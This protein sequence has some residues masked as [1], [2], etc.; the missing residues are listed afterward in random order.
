MPKK[1]PPS[2]HIAGTCG[3]N[4]DI[5]TVIRVGLRGNHLVLSGAH[6]DTGAVLAGDI[7]M[8]PEKVTFITMAFGGVTVSPVRQLR[9]VH[10]M[11]AV[12]GTL[13]VTIYPPLKEGIDIGDIH[14]NL[15]EGDTVTILPSHARAL[16]S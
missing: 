11:D 4:G 7:M 9:V 3:E 15:E 14:Q 5:L 16:I 10:D 1:Y 2:L 6:C 8:L 13:V 12:A